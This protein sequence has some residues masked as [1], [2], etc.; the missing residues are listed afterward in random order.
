MVESRPLEVGM[1]GEG[2]QEGC[3]L[4]CVLTLAVT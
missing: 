2:H 3:A 1:S 4:V